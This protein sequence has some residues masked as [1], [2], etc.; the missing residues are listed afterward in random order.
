MVATALCLPTADEEALGVG[1]LTMLSLRLF[2][3]TTVFTKKEP[4]YWSVRD[5]RTL[6]QLLLLLLLACLWIMLCVWYPS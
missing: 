4:L 1:R 2:H 6:K 5:G 3:S